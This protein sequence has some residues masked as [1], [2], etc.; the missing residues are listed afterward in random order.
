MPL[1]RVVAVASERST[2]IDPVT[3]KPTTPPRVAVDVLDAKVGVREATGV[4]VSG[5][6]VQ[7]SPG[8]R[9]GDGNWEAVFVGESTQPDE[10]TRQNNASNAAID[11]LT[12]RALV[13]ICISSPSARRNLGSPY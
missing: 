2:V 6:G 5:C 7:Q 1:R 13:S 3:V 12:V 8:V 10:A 9:V 11:V 4:G